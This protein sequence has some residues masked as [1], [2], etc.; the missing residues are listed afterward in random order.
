MCVDWTPATLSNLDGTRLTITLDESGEPVV[1]DLPEPTTALALV[2]EV[3]AR[4][5]YSATK[6]AV[7]SRASKR[8]VALPAA[9][10]REACGASECDLIGRGHGSHWVPVLRA[11]NGPAGDWVPAEVLSARG[12]E[13]TLGT[14]GGEV[15]V[16]FHDPAALAGTG[17]YNERWGVLRAGCEALLSFSPIGPCSRRTPVP[18][19]WP[20]R[21]TPWE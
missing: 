18:S 11:A 12:T 6:Q 19:P 3:G 14:P 15:T 2:R 4:F 5:E 8:T 10:N 16:W 7:R 21:T 13:I 17:T 20:L 9:L 1:F